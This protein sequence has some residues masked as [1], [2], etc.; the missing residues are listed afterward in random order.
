MGGGRVGRTSVIYMY[1]VFLYHSRIM[2]SQIS[3]GNENWFKK[4][5][6]KLIANRWAWGR[7]PKKCQAWYMP[8]AG[9]A[10]IHG[11]PKSSNH[12]QSHWLNQWKSVEILTN[13][14]THHFYQWLEGDDGANC[15]MQA[16]LE[17]HNNCTPSY[18]WNTN[19]AVCSST[20][21][22]PNAVCSLAVHWLNSNLVTLKLQYLREGRWLLVQDFGRF[23]KIRVPRYFN[24]SRM[25]L[26]VCSHPTR[27]HHY[28]KF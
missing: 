15:T 22:G 12:A 27:A 24:W 10:G 8:W 4:F 23:E 11:N 5:E 17:A 1:T 2:I 21:H 3:K 25:I 16:I 7:C 13:P 14:H 9:H 6:V 28:L 26:L 20:V 19:H 18:S